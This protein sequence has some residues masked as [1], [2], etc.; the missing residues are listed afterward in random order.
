M[1][2]DIRFRDLDASNALKNHATRRLQFGLRRFGHAIN[3]VTLRVSDV[4]GPRGGVDKRCHII[5][6]GPR[7]GTIA[8]DE[9]HGD[10]YLAVDAAVERLSRTVGRE[11]ARVRSNQRAA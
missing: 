5:A 7:L 9:L 3:G 4:N 6:H 1:K 2:I 8:V 11:L 10:I